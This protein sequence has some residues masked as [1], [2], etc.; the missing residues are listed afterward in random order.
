MALVKHPIVD[1]FKLEALD[2]MI[3][4]A[5]AL[6]GELAAHVG[7]RLN[8]NIM[9]GFGM[10]ETSP[11]THLSDVGI[12]PLESIGMPLPNTE[13]KVVDITDEQLHEITP[14]TEEGERSA[15]REMWIRGPQVMLGYL[16]NP[17]A[18]AKTL[19]A[20]GWLRTGDIVNL[21]HLGNTY[22]VDRMKELIKYKG[23]QVAP[24]ELEALLMTRDDVADVA[25]VG[26]TREDDGEEV[27][28]AFVVRQV[29]GAGDCMDIDPAELMAWV[30]ERV[31]PYKKIRMVDFLNSVPKSNTGKILRKD[32]RNV[33][34]TSDTAMW[35]ASYSA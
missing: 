26:F 21:D 34:T 23:Y 15:D 27:P 6:D 2:T 1:K 4:G 11:V 7:K 5:A 13:S 3:S 17:E 18:D 12:T 31:A 10:T 30:A 22:V 32:L 8:C 33:P 35:N 16:N 14:P 9:Q 19:I 28:R 24:A 20:D 25:V 29:T